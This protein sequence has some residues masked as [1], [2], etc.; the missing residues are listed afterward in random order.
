MDMQEFRDSVANDQPPENLNFALTGLWWDA[1]GD[2]TAYSGEGGQLIRSWRTAPERSD[3]SW[4][5]R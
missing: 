1:K 5:V 2:W 3:V 4:L